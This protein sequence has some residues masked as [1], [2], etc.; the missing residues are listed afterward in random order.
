MTVTETV[1]V[2]ETAAA[3]VAPTQ[4]A[5][6]PASDAA[7]KPSDITRSQEQAIG[8]AESYLE[9]THFSKKGLIGQLSSEYGEGFSEADATFAVEYLEDN[10]LVDWM[11]QAVGSAESYLEFTHFSRQGLIDQLMSEYGEQFTQAQAE[12]AADAVGL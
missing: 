9:F 7:P 8:S 6:E 1:T 10:G 2:T 12:H 4:E 5:E 11:E 3:T